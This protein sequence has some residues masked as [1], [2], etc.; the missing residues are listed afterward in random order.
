MDRSA[1]VDLLAARAAAMAVDVDDDAIWSL[2]ARLS[3]A[4]DPNDELRDIGVR[5]AAGWTLADIDHEVAILAGTGATQ[6][7]LFA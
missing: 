1:A 7:G 5:M 4:N 2:A 6:G 3:V